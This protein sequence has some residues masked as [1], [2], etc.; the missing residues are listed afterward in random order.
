[1]ERQLLETKRNK[2]LLIHVIDWRTGEK[3]FSESSRAFMITARNYRCI[4]NN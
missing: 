1:M 3:K 2:K 4:T